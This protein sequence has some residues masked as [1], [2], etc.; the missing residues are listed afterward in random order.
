MICVRVSLGTA[1]LLC[2]ASGL[3]Q[4]AL[5][6]SLYMFAL[7]RLP[8]NVAGA[9]LLLTPLAGLLEAHAFLGEQLTAGQWLASAVAL[10]AVAAL[11]VI[12]S[13]PRERATWAPLQI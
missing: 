11:S 9:L 12:G 2:A 7:R 3:L 5:P 8:A 6:F 10:A 13:R 1:L 4:F